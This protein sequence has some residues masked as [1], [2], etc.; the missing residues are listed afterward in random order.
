[1][2]MIRLTV[3]EM[4]YISLFES[5]TGATAKDCVIAEDNSYIIFVVKQGEVGL[6]IGRNG[7]NIKRLK[8]YISKPIDIVE[9]SDKPKEFIKNTFAPARLTAIEILERADGKKIAR[10]EVQPEDRGIAIG[11]NGRN[12]AKARILAKRHFGIEDIKLK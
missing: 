2:S 5:I 3:D 1:M 10:V 4:S 9:Y 6:A 12:I 11:R 7:V 8:Q